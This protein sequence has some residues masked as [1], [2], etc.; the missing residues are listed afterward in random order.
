MS[1]D[2]GENSPC[3]AGGPEWPLW[4]HHE[5]LWICGSSSTWRRL[6]K[7][8]GMTLCQWMD[9][10]VC[11]WTRLSPW[12][13]AVPSET[14]SHLSSWRF[15]LSKVISCCVGSVRETSFSLETSVFSKKTIFTWDF[16]D[17]FTRLRKWLTHNRKRSGNTH[18][19]QAQVNKLRNVKLCKLTF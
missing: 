11:W 12:S 8:K 10:E 17:L 7:W 18:V 3:S 15:S 2:E 14:F 19:A 13:T 9:F 4:V 16:W 6:H 1:A 5:L